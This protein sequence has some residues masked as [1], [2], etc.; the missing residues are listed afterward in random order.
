MIKLFPLEFSLFNKAS[1]LHKVESLNKI[2]L[3]ELEKNV[4]NK[5]SRYNLGDFALAIDKSISKAI[6]N[7]RFS[8]I[9]SITSYFLFKI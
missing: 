1:L 3:K 6:T 9:S 7:S 5:I 8:L 2:E 4:K